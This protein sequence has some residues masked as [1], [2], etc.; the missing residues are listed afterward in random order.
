MR[1][2]VGRMNCG[3]EFDLIERLFAEPL[4]RSGGGRALAHAQA[5]GIG[6]D[7]AVLAP[8]PA[9]QQ[10]VFASDLL[11]EGHHYFPEVDPRSLGHKMLAVNCSD[12]AAMGAEPLACTLSMAIRRRRVGPNASAQDQNWLVQL[13]Q[14]LQDLAAQTGCSLVGGDTVGLD[15]E[16]PESFSIAIIGTVPLGQALRRDGLQ[17][18]DQIWVSG[19]L[20]D[21]AW[22][23][24][25]RIAHQRLNWP[26]PRLALGRALRGLAHAAIDVSDGLSSELGHLAAAS[27]RRLEQPLVIQVELLALAPCLGPGLAG[28]LAS[29]ELSMEQACRL[30]AASGDEYEL[31]F[32]APAAAH[33][34]VMQVGRDLGLPLTPIGWVAQAANP[35]HDSQTGPT[36]AVGSVVWLDDQQSPLP[37]ERAPSAGFDHFGVT[38]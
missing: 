2:C 18:G 38:A 22:A 23:V 3:P 14:G 28:Q 5:L 35:S 16:Q 6:D 8:L 32:A 26:Q 24:R 4:R 9:D 21:G 1:R 12:L 10:L 27:A 37:A 33:D 30:A 25:Q 11:V 7:A 34:Q 29:G 31:C 15:D 36:V 19:Q 20:G 13:A 17:P